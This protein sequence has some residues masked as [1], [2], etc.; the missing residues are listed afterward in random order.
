MKSKRSFLNST[1]GSK[2]FVGLSGLALSFFVL[3]HMLGNLLI[4]MGPEAYNNY[5]H[6]IVSNPAIYLA[7]AGLVMLFL[8]HVGLA[9]KLTRENKSARPNDYAVSA[10]GEKETSWIQKTM[11]HQGIVIFTFVIWHLVTFKYGPHYEYTSLKSGEVIRDLYKL[12]VE[13]F[14][15]PSYLMGY[16]VG[17]IVLSMHLSH[18]LSSA[19]RTLG[20]NHPKY[21][22]KVRCFGKAYALIVLLGF[23]SQPIYIYFTN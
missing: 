18:G 13:V 5:G 21:D 8:F 11:I 16:A 3:T 7:E 20:F 23:L 4:F 22:F 15:S 19:I 17:L 2:L 14:K 12:L 9:I 10:S 6:A 1:I